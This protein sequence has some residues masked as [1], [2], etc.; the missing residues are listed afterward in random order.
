M[1][2]NWVGELRALL[3]P[4]S[5]PYYAKR[6]SESE[7][8]ALEFALGDGFGSPS[9]SASEIFVPE[10]IDQKL[11]KFRAWSPAGTPLKARPESRDA[12]DAFF[13]IEEKDGL[14][15]GPTEWQPLGFSAELAAIYFERQVRRFRKS[16][17]Q[18]AGTHLTLSEL[19]EMAHRRVFEK[20][21]FEYHAMKLIDAMSLGPG[22]AERWIKE[23]AGPARMAFEI[24]VALNW[25]GQLGRLVERYYWTRLFER[26]T[27]AGV[28]LQEGGREG[29][30]MRSRA[31]GN[32]REWQKLADERWQRTPDAS[33]TQ[34][35]LYV[36]K[37]LRLTVT[38]KN[39]ARYL[40]KP[41]SSRKL[42]G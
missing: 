25:A 18:K 12:D 2:R 23:G 10:N 29:A 1:A 28:K 35:A 13:R 6:F 26:A 16:E 22:E 42:R 8:T 32:H 9:G 30:R 7:R 3:P 14:I 39:V 40:V 38:A 20:P 19:D 31:G 17:R 41:A 36:Q 15:P 4:V 21:W 34:V 33:K 37:T 27:V 24:H 11:L 5:E